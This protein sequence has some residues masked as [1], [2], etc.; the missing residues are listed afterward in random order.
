M[1]AMVPL[2]SSN[3]NMDMTSSENNN[4]V[5]IFHNGTIE[6]SS[7]NIDLTP[8][9]SRAPVRLERSDITQHKH[10]LDHG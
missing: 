4:S 2:F 7:N 8:G 5:H 1:A 10:I 3:L 9:I 6:M